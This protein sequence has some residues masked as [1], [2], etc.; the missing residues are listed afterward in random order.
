MLARSDMHELR[1]CR[2]S[3]AV[4]LMWCGLSADD[5]LARSDVAE[6]L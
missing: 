4:H 2:L 6:F 3:T 5:W 1:Q